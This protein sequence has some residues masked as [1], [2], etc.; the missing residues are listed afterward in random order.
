MMPAHAVV[1][2]TLAAV[3]V[4]KS[5]PCAGGLS[6]CFPLQKEDTVC[7]PASGCCSKA[8]RCSFW[9][10]TRSWQLRRLATA[11]LSGAA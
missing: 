2:V 8:G 4:G 10:C 7:F 6:A 1:A 5:V 11:S 9:G 3:P